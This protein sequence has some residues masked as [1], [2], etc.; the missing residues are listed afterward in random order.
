[1]AKYRVILVWTHDIDFGEIEAKSEAEAKEIAETRLSDDMSLT[2][3]VSLPDEW[4][5]EE[6]G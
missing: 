6:V 2:E 4:T 1:M 3:N 5:I